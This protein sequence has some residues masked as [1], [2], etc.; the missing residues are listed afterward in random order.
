MS[1]DEVRL[2]ILAMIEKEGDPLLSSTVQAVR[3]EMPI[4]SDGEIMVGPFRC[5]L[6]ENVFVAT[7][8]SGPI[9]AEFA[10]RFEQKKDSS[11]IAILESETRN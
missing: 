4:E 9:F 2:A 3:D 8:D 6:K 10:G 7:F 1:I 5:D 11:W